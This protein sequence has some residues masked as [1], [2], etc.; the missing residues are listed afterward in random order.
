MSYSCMILAVL[1]R[2][3]VSVSDLKKASADNQM[4]KDILWYIHNNYNETLSEQELA[5]KYHFSKEYFCRMFKRYTGTTF[6]K[7]LQQYR[8]IKAADMLGK[9]KY[10]L[11]QIAVE[12]GYSN[13]QYFNKMFT[14]YY[15]L[16]PGRYRKMLKK[17]KM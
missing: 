9:E 4:I 13:E 3:S 7:Y 2:N 17:Q 16:T 6:C 1:L 5:E 8:L 15:G 10:S 14:K 11:L 12:V